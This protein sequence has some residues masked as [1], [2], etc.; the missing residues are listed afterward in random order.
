MTNARSLPSER[1]GIVVLLVDDITEYR[2][3]LRRQL[4]RR[5]GTL[6]VFEAANSLEA[7]TLLHE[8]PVDVVVSDFKMPGMNGVAFL[9]E[10]GRLWPKTR[11]LLLTAYSTDK[12]Q[13]SLPYPVLDKGLH[14]W[15]ILDEVIR[16]ARLR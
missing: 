8:T 5:S 13:T 16:L 4:E 15:V 10:V 9:E 12:Q 3:V 6:A 14:L 11:R 2:H 1:S 7:L